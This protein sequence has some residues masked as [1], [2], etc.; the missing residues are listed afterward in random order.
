MSPFFIIELL[1]IG[2]L[3]ALLFFVVLLFVKPICTQ[4]LVSKAHPSC[5]YLES[6]MR[7]DRL[8]MLDGEEVSPDGRLLFF[9]HGKKVQRTIVFFHGNTNSPRQFEALGKI[10]YEKGY[11]VLIPRVP[12][13]GLKDRM[14]KDLIRLTALELTKLCD[15]SVDIALG[16]GKHVTV[17]GFS[18]GA[19]MAGWLAQKRSD[20]DKAVIIAPFWGWKGLLIGFFRPFINLLFILPNKFVWWDRKGKMALTGPTSSYYRFS[21]RAVAQIM[22]LGWSVMKEVGS[23]APKVRAIVVITSAI[24]DAVNEKNLNRIVDKWRGHN[25]VKITRFQFDKDT[26]AFHDMI[27]PQQPYQKTAVV[28]PK[29]IELIEA[30]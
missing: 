27:D 6:V 19:N 4:H 2:L 18:M 28:Y 15:E 29:L 30:S 23:V 1:G 9:E 17:V 12:H 25:G 21:T 14:T 10:F 13:H 20:V 8:R 11:N 22:C 24:D 3:A 26:C 7:I 5:S 16:L